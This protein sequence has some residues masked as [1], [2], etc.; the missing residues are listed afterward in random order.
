[1]P[2]WLYLT[3][4]VPQLQ[5]VWKDYGIAALILPA[6]S[7]IGHPDLA[8]VI[9]QTGRVRGELGA[10]PGPG[11]HRPESSFAVL[12]AGAARRA[13]RSSWTGAPGSRACWR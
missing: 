11:N 3:G 4:S 13:L 10:D 2:N 8:W 5:Q 6:G 7:M 12:L 1:M 9:D